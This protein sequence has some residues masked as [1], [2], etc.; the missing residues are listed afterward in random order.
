MTSLSASLGK[1]SL[2]SVGRQEIDDNSI[3]GVVVGLSEAVIAPGH[4]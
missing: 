1:R 2:V 3:Q 4:V